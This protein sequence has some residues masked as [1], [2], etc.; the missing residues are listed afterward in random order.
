VKRYIGMRDSVVLVHNSGVA[1][2]I[3]YICNLL[4]SIY[5]SDM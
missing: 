4:Q 3:I 2:T 5:K 1:Y